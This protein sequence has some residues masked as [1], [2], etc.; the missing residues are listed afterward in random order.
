VNRLI[1]YLHGRRIGE[2]T[3]AEDAPPVFTYDAVYLAEG[4]AVPLSR[5]LP[6]Q[7]DPFSGRIVRA[8]FA[9]ILPEADARERIAAILGISAENDF[10]LMERIGGEC[11]GSVSLLSPDAPPPAQGEGR[12]RW[13]N[14]DELAAIIREL[15]RRP[16]MAG[17]DGVRLS[18]A[19]AQAKLPVILPSAGDASYGEAALPLDGAPSTH[20]IKP[21][22]ER[23]PGL[24]ANEAFCMALARAVGLNAAETEWRMIGDTPCLIARRY[25]RVVG[26]DDAVERIHQEDFCQALGIPPERKYQQEGGPSLP[27][28][29][30]LLRD[31]STVPVLDVPE[32]LDA[33]I[34]GVLIGNAD[35]HAKNFS[36]LYSGAGRRL[37]PLY[38][39]VCT[40]A[41]PEL[42]KTLS[43]KIG[44]A[45]ILPEVSPEHFRHLASKAG[46]GW[47]MARE[48]LSDMCHRVSEAVT[49]IAIHE[50]A[51]DVPSIILDRAKRGIRLLER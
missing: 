42:S 24:A 30:A 40:L 25:D 7:A 2:L 26:A 48:R 38:D 20:I 19:G 51:R 8:F 1:V 50:S 36:F 43:M 31:W 13:L 12:L 47:P 34:F 21:E 3:Q 23:F 35:A 46:L 17:E 39:Q 37:A 29:F 14:A 10:G 16:L 33:V 18:L 11:A 4:D 9:G 6:L 15:P 45:A 41:W 28:C 44:S 5:Q 49:R 22:P 32:F 27:D